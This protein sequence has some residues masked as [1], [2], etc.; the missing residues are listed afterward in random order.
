MIFT[1]NGQRY[2][3]LLTERFVSVWMLLDEEYESFAGRRT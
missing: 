3:V 1:R 2:V